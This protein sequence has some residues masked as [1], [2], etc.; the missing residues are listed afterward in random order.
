MTEK[1]RK[2]LRAEPGSH[3]VPSMICSR[4]RKLFKTRLLLRL[5]LKKQH[6][7][8]RKQ[9]ADTLGAQTQNGIWEEGVPSL[10]DGCGCCPSSPIS[11]VTEPDTW[12]KEF[13]GQIALSFSDASLSLR[14]LCFSFLPFSL[15][16]DTTFLMSSTQFKH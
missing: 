2:A 7:E 1:P 3:M 12:I 14:K 4:G 6:W 5:A 8:R 16:R 11:E 9:V 13:T 15:R 10:L